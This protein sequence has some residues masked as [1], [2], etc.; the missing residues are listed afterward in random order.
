MTPRSPFLLLTATLLATACAGQDRT[1][2]VELEPVPLPA[3][4]GDAHV[5]ERTPLASA[6]L[7][8]SGWL[9]RFEVELVDGNGRPL[10]QYMLHHVNVMVPEQRDL[11]RPIMQRLVAAGE[12][13]EPI[14]LP[15][16]LGVRAAEGQELLVF[17][18]LHNPTDIDHGD[19][20]V[21]VKLHYARSP[22]LSVQ[23]LFIDAS[24]PPGPAG[25]D[26]P[27]GRST[28][29]WE[30]RAAVDGRILALGGHLHRY[31]VELVLEDVTAGRVLYR[32][33]PV[34]DEDG[35][36]AHVPRRTFLGRM[37]H[38]IRQ[39]HTYRIT[40]VYENPTGE[41]IPDGAMGAVGGV[42]RSRR[43]GWIAADPDDPLYRQ[44]LTG[45][46]SGLPGHDHHAG[47]AAPG[48]VD[49]HAGH[50]GH[51]GHVH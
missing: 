42:I 4:N 20:T 43:G 3:A 7:P 36:V 12:E 6:R 11:F 25:W 24:P 48:D 15:W 19:V 30:G 33:R 2:V 41:T 38:A 22:R 51:D 46:D 17:G 10:P 23:P 1:F 14:D 45:L 21:R 37:G 47:S 16:P 34:L 50:D 35:A 49:P 32:E 29:S 18:M 28:R 5:M 40:V 31:G 13:T 27:P 9:T 44:D 39:D 8:A 26:L